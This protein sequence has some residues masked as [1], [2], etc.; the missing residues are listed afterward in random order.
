MSV[1]YSVFEMDYR[2]PK[3]ARYPIR[4]RLLGRAKA[5]RERS[6]S[7]ELSQFAGE[8]SLV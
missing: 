3:A 1:A 6:E 5:R 2:N 4:L 8:I 7:R